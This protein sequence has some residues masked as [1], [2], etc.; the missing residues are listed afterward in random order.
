MKKILLLTFVLTFSVTTFAISL[1]CG[2][3]KERIQYNSIEDILRTIDPN[4]LP[5]TPYQ[6]DELYSPYIE[7]LDQKANDIRNYVISKYGEDLSNLTNKEVIVLGLIMIPFEAR[8]AVAGRISNEQA[9]D[10]M[11]TAIGVATGL[12]ALYSL[13]TTGAST[14]TILSTLKAI[15]K[16]GGGWFAVGYGVWKFGQC[17]GWW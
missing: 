12:N 14:A 16:F 3:G 7:V 13:W 1:Y 11:M 10:C 17:V 8:D 4:I 15:L 5:H 6:S 2:V 9:F